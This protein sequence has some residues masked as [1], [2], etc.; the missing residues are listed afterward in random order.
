MILKTVAM[1]TRVWRN[2]KKKNPG[3]RKGSGRWHR[4]RN[5]MTGG[6]GG[7][8]EGGGGGGEGPSGGVG[9]TRV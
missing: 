7:R 3:K 1:C 2:E 6:K 8:G 9:T 4:A 5:G